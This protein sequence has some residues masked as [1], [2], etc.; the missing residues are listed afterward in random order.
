M[1]GQTKDIIRMVFVEPLLM[2]W[3]TVH[4]PKCRHM[5]H[6]LIRLSVEQIVTCIVTMVP[7]WYYKKNTEISSQFF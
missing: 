3:C 7:G 6:Y 1:N 2:A 4:Y 5:E